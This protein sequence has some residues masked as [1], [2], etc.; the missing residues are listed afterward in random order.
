MFQAQALD[1]SRVV[2][3]GSNNRRADVASGTRKVVTFTRP[4]KLATVAY[5][6]PAGSYT[7]ET[8][9]ERLPDDRPVGTFLRLPLPSG[10][11]GMAPRLMIDP[12]E[13]EAALARDV[14]P[15]PYGPSPEPYGPETVGAHAAREV[16]DAG[17]S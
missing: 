8:V 14:A 13:L 7:I 11:A 6:L 15:E 12:V 9:V 10:A 5:R 4:F 17:R 1:F 2:P 16:R 3:G